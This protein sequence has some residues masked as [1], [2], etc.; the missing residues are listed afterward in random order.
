MALTHARSGQVVS[1]LPFGN[2]VRDARTTAI[3][4]ADQ[5][6]V[7]RIVLPAGKGLAEHSVP[8]KITAVHRRPH[9]VTDARG[10]ARA[11]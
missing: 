7:V 10:L 2:Q 5:L 9:R 3:L 6:E 4:K 11:Q 1:V 8:D